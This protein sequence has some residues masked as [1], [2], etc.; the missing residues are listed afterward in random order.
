[1]FTFVR[2]FIFTR[3][4]RSRIRRYNRVCRRTDRLRTE[5]YFY[6]PD[7]RFSGRLQRRIAR[8]DTRCALLAIKLCRSQFQG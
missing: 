6:S 2:R 5:S 8:L 4:L 3:V 1:M 7:C